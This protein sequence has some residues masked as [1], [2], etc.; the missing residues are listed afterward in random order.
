MKDKVYTVVICINK[1]FCSVQSSN[2]TCPAGQSEVC[3]HVGAL[4]YYLVN[5][6]TACTNKGCTWVQPDDKHSE[7]IKRFCDISIVNTVDKAE[8]SIKPY[9]GVYRAGPCA[10]PDQ[11][12]KDVIAG[13]G[14]VN[15]DCVLYKVM[16]KTVDNI[17][18]FVNVYTPNHCFSDSVDLSCKVDALQ[19]YVDQLD[20][21]S[22]ICVMIEKATKGQHSNI[23][24]D[25][26][27]KKL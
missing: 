5:V 6:R 18:P 11:F 25:V 16:C 4:L 21:S 26:W 15:P 7:T 27:R 19:T 9:P 8:S 17:D 1:E 13:L 22:D 14:E 12:Y 20:I 3:C 2:C 23:M 10:D 24:V